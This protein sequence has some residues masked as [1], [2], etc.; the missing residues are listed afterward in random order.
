ME[1][2]RYYGQKRAERNIKIVQIEPR[3]SLAASRADK[4]I[5]VKPGTEG[6][7]AL[8][9]ASIIIREKLYDEIFLTKLKRLFRK[10]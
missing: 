9:I 1:I 2:Q 5:P 6:L 7:L 8:G 4:W 10:N 3:F